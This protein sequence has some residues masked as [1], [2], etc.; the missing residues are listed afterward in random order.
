MLQ[1]QEVGKKFPGNLWKALTLVK[2]IIFQRKK[3][4]HDSRK[5][6]LYSVI[7]LELIKTA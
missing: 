3:I 5:E 1:I 7:W 6:R 4:F 2:L